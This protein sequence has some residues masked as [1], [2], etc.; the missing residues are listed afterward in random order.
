MLQKKFDSE[1]DAHDCFNA[2]AKVRGFS[3]RKDSVKFHKNNVL[4]Y[5][6][7]VCSRQGRRA[8]QHLDRL[9]RKRAPRAETRLG[10]Q[11]T[12]SI[13][14]D[15][16]IEKYVIRKFY[17]EH[18]HQLPESHVVPFLWSYGFVSGADKA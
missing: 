7:W 1:K 12:F 8:K 13:N 4:V 17:D 5:R 18:N 6:K 15:W 9:D 3:I 10:C 11:A 14:Y 2:Y 16:K